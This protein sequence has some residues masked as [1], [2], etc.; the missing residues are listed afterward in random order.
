MTGPGRYGEL[1]IATNSGFSP[2]AALGHKELAQP[3]LVLAQRSFCNF[4]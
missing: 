3:I 4:S 1:C 2:V